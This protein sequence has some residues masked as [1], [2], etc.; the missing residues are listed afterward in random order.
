[1]DIYIGTILWIL[2][3][4]APIG[5]IYADGQCLPINNNQALYSL[6]GNRFGGD[7][8]T[9]FCV[10]DLRPKNQNGVPEWGNGPRAVIVVQGMYP[11]RP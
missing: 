7:M 4:Y 11:S 8:R 2:T 5:T 1:M 9:N 10:P 6:V 3:T